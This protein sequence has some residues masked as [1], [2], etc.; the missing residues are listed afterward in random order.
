LP[1]SSERATA[2]AWR[3]L[4]EERTRPATEHFTLMLIAMLW[5]LLRGG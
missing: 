2:E 1:Y 3:M 5:A 4:A